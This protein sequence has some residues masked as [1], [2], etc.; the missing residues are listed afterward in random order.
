MP[1]SHGL[2]APKVIKLQARFLLLPVLQLYSFI[3][4]GDCGGS[5]EG[6]YPNVPL[7]GGQLL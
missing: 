4:Q 2:V 1:L 3:V 7:A 5:E 6:V